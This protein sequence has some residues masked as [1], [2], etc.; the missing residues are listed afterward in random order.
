MNTGTIINS[1]L[2][3]PSFNGTFP[4]L[5]QFILDLVDAHR[6]GEIKSWDDLD[7]RVKKIFTPERMEQTEK[8][9]PGWIKMASYSDGITLTHVT[10][11]FLGVYMLPEFQSLTPEQQQMA[12]WIVMFHDLDKFHIRGKRDTMH[13]FRSGIL[14]AHTL[15][16]LGFPITG[17]YH[18]L[19]GSW[20]ELTLHASIE[21]SRDTAPTPDNQKLPEILAGIDQLFG[22]NTPASLITK[23][24]LLHIS[25][26]IDP[27]YPTPA[28]LTDAEIKRFITPDLI[29]LLKVMMMGDNEGWSLFDPE[30]RKRQY[31]DTREA[32]EKVQGLITG[33]ANR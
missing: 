29:P 3:F 27:F 11:V 23:T 6:T 8:L 18:D 1:A 9:V 20:S 10:C 12:K 31:K 28:P 17:K 30:V 15:P 24:V 13:G 21:R 25:L 2:L 33:N 4:F 16:T 5:N 14:A 26:S 32:F 19:L 22:E 7:E